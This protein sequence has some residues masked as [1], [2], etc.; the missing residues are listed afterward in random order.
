MVEVED[1]GG[2]E[3]AEAHDAASDELPPPTPPASKD[4]SG[5]ERW[6]LIR[7]GMV[8]VLT[9]GAFHATFT[10]ILHQALA[11]DPI[12]F[13]IAAPVWAGL[14]AYGTRLRLPTALPINDRQVDWT[15][16]ALVFIPF[17]VIMELM[18]PRLGPSSQLW[19]VDVLGMWMFLL[20]ANILL[21]GLRSVGRYL[22]VWLFLM[23]C[24]PIIFLGVGVSLGGT[25]ADY[26][27]V[28]VAYGAVATAL[29]VDGGWRRW[30][31]VAGATG[32]VGV[33]LIIAT[34]VLPPI[35]ERLVPGLLAALG[36]TIAIRVGIIRRRPFV[37]QSRSSGKVVTKL[38]PTIVGLILLGVFL[39][40]TSP[41]VPTG[42]DLA[43]LVTARTSML[44][45]PVR[46]NG[47]KVQG[48]QA[49]PKVAGF[50][51]PGASWLRVTYRGTRR[52]D[53]FVL[54]ALTTTSPGL[55]SVY[56][57]Q[58][59]YTYLTP[60]AAGPDLVGACGVR[61]ESFGTNIAAIDTQE[62]QIFVAVTFLWRIQRPK[63]PWYQRIT[64]F[65]P[66]GPQTLGS[67][68]QP[69]KPITV[70]S[71]GST[72]TDII[73]GPLLYTTLPTDP[74]ALPRAEHFADALISAEVRSQG[75]HCDR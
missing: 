17:I 15:A 30:P 68:P 61:E 50:F 70:G 25:T 35:V 51:G 59:N 6:V 23:A 55:L 48:H 14:I 52:S 36:V 62:H 57:T 53:L 27:L 34:S 56:P 9:I 58:V 18:A 31:L 72:L 44:V 21:F 74:Q 39:G 46:L 64:V 13:L 29:S 63:G 3:V 28:G 45:H 16:A 49:L 33:L 7:W 4:T 5:E 41:A 71:V 10:S 65:A 38:R 12:E 60:P 11:G 2:V 22:S 19:R 20:M 54:D 43:D 40:V 69:V 8:G 67:I 26:A 24:W 66:V 47:Y 37:G 1:G 73:R 75:G 42:I 32:V